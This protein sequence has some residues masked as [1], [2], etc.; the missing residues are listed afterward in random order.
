M[1]VFATKYIRGS[2]QSQGLLLH[3]LID[4]LV[5][6]LLLDLMLTEVMK[7]TGNLNWQSGEYLG[8]YSKF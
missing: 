5:G 4:C 2:R 6:L 1:N 7:L 8:V 3:I